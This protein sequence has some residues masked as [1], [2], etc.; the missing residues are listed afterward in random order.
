MAYYNTCPD[1]GSKAYVKDFGKEALVELIIQKAK[2][3]I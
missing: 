2:G 3:E 1:C